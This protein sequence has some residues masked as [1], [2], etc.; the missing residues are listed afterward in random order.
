MPIS[1]LEIDGL[2]NLKRVSIEPGDGF[3]FIFGPNGSGKTS[4]LEAIHCLGRGKSFRTHKTNNLISEGKE[5]FT[6]VGHVRQRE[7]QF[8]IGIQRRRGSS[9]IRLAGQ[10]VTRAGE[11]S[12][13]LPIAVLEPGQ[14]RLVEEGPEYRRKFL[15]WGVFHVEH[16]FGETWRNY[17]RAL[18]QRNAAL[19]LRWPQKAVEKWDRELVEAGRRL[20]TY[21]RAYL[22][23]FRNHVTRLATEFFSEAFSELAS[24]QI[25]YQQGWREGV[26]YADYLR[27]QFASDRERGFTQFGPHRA[28]LRLRLTRMEARDVLSRG[29]QKILVMLLVLAQCCLLTEFGTPIVVLVDDLPAELDAQRREALMQTLASTEAQIFVTATESDLFATNVLDAGQVFHVEQGQVI[30]VR[31]SSVVS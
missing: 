27:V 12:E 8:T 20:D 21:R 19:R 15:D 16:T 7:R 14:H 28:D 29:Q 26:E 13:N 18:A 10:S 3:N 2:R 24:L 25:I 4:L 31:P 30:T 11:L 17:R 23:N 6:V 1:Q 22:D 5:S 9:D